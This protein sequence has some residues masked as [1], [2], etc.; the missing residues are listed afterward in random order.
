MSRHSKRLSIYIAVFAVVG[1]ATLLYSLAASTDSRGFEA[2]AGQRS[3]AVSVQT[4]GGSS[5]GSVRLNDTTSLK[6]RIIAMTDGEADD[7]DSFVR[8][9]Y[10]VN[11]FE[12][13]GVVHTNS[14]WQ[15]NGH[16]RG[17]IDTQIDAYAQILNNLRVHDP[18]YPTA[19]YIRAKVMLGIEDV[20]TIWGEPPF[21]DTPGS[22][23]IIQELLND[24][25]RPLYIGAW[26]GSNTAA[27]ALYK[28]KTNY[29]DKYAAAAKKAKLFMIHSISEGQD[30]GWKWIGDNIPEAEV[31]VNASYLGTWDYSGNRNPYNDELKSG[32][33]L[34]ANVKSGHGPLGALYAQNYI[35]EGDTPAF[36][37]LVNNGLRSYE[38][39][40]YGGWSGRFEKN[41]ANVWKDS[42]DDGSIYKA[43]YRWFPAAQNDFSARMDWT[44]QSYANANHAPKI[45]ISDSLDRTIAPGAVVQLSAQVSDPDG[46][47]TTLQWWQYNEADTAS[48]VTITGATNASGA[49]FTA[50][51]EPGK[52]IHLIL[53]VT[54]NGTPSLKHYARIVYTIAQ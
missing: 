23:L 5:A 7:R 53:E 47:S 54:D 24:D 41:Y 2:E 31:I 9:L 49:Q 28:L 15:P 20:S 39:P 48:A 1:V 14:R 10:Y 50:P 19:E 27:H 44:T 13:K 21:Y 18:A 52:T 11:D 12:V 35:S 3:G 6:P 43:I 22:D 33:W 38:H 4:G 45:V 37:V 16:G 29:P 34:N 32:A 25:P 17:W 8:F 30:N 26:G 42:P 51:N 36:M 40:T 46:D